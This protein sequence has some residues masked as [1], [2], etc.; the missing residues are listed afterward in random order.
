MVIQRRDTDTLS[1]YDAGRDHPEQAGPAPSSSEDL[2]AKTSPRP[3]PSAVPRTYDSNGNSSRRASSPTW[4]QF[5]GGTGTDGTRV[6]VM[7]VREDDQPDRYAEVAPILRN[8]MRYMDDVFAISSMETGG[9]KRVRWVHDGACNLSV[10]NVVLPDGSI[11]GTHA[12][13]E[14]ALNTAGYLKAQRKYLAFADVPIGGLGGAACGQGTVYNDTKP[15]DNLND[16][17]YP[18]MARI[19]LECWV[20]DDRYNAAPLHEFLHTLGAVMPEAPHGTP[21]TTAPTA[22]R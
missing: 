14:A 8:E 9:G 1:L 13:T 10:L 17:R 7:Y 12:K 2:S 19:D 5:C 15:T 22:R 16:G 20:T 6:Q 4:T 11:T 18:Q 21:G 3:L